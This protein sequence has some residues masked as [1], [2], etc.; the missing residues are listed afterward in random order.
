MKK[1]IIKHFNWLEGELGKPTLLS[2]SL[3]CLYVIITLLVLVVAPI[4][5]FD[6]M[7][8][9][10]I[11]GYTYN[12]SCV[13]FF[14]IVYILYILYSYRPRTIVKIKTKHCIGE[15]NKRG[16]RSLTKN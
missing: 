12:F 4:I 9:K 13:F 10:T 15:Y 1:Q 6:K 16:C 7:G 11:N 3:F 2:V 5:Y 14:S 8:M